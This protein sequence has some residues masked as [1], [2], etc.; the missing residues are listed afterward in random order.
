MNGRAAFAKVQCS[1]PWVSA[2][3]EADQSVRPCYFQPQIGSV[4]NQSLLEVLNSP[5]TLAFRESLDVTSDA[6][7]ERCVCSLYIPDDT[8]EPMLSAR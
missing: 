7:C 5:E 2:V 1:A 3:T 8:G 6:I 4:S